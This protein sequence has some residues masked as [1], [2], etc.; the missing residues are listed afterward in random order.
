MP[1]KAPLLRDSVS[2]LAENSDYAWLSSVSPECV[3]SLHQFCDE[4][5]QSVLGGPNFSYQKSDLE[6]AI[7][8][9]GIDAMHNPYAERSR[10]AGML[11]VLTSEGVHR[12]CEV[13]LGLT[14]AVVH[15]RD[16][17]SFL[18]KMFFDPSDGLEE[19]CHRVSGAFL[20]LVDRRYRDSQSLPWD[21][22][23]PLEILK[24]L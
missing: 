15:N 5:H 22:S 18:G 12:H 9:F 24:T 3:E 19:N 17:G 2:L 1:D 20:E 23:F 10:R 7:E 4:V 6:R 14:Y 13:L 8:S 11:T 21:P 16:K